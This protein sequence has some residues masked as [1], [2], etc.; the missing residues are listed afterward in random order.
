M[1]E[2]SLHSDALNES[3]QAT[4]R[5]FDSKEQCAI[6]TF[7]KALPPNSKARLSVSFRA[8]ITGRMAGYYKSLGGADSKTICALTQFQ[9]GSSPF[10]YCIVPDMLFSAHRCEASI[11]LLG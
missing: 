7:A 6:F 5:D 8:D 11:P 9:V 3:Q 2:V 4:S 1:D 10:V